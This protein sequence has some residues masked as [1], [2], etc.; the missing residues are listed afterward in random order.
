MNEEHFVSGSQDGSI[1]LWSVKKKKPVCYLNFGAKWIT[2]IGTAYNSDLVVAGSYDSS[3]KFVKIA[4]DQK[5]MECIKEIELVDSL[6]TQFSLG[7]FQTSKSL[8]IDHS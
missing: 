5:S 6:I 8:A 4:P 1:G 3:L 2:S 7:L